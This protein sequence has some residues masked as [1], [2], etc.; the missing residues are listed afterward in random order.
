MPTNSLPASKHAYSFDL[1][2]R[3]YLREVLVYLN[4][5]EGTY[6]L[7]ANVVDIAPP[8]VG[9]REA[10]RLNPKG[11]AWEI[12]VNFRGVM[13]WDIA[14]G[15]PVPNTLQLGDVPAAGTTAEP[16]PIFSD[17]EPVR[18]VWNTTSHAWRQE[19]D[20]SRFPVWWKATGKLA[21]AVPSGQPLP[22]TLTTLSPPIPGVHQ[23]VQWNDE[24]SVW[25]LIADFRGFV[26]WT[27]DGEQHAI[28]QL[29]VV[30]PT[31][32][33]TAPPPTSEAPP[34]ADSTTTEV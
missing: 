4:P 18:N 28:G 25:V 15:R 31:G 5:E 17:A 33:L 30:P 11:D 23:T 34:A 13:L 24:H 14:T 6:Y 1:I 7:P 32:Y 8:S 16:P 29:G 19:P 22:G 12:V 9:A 21:P 3:E 27:A 26:Y 20:Y 10:A 2:T